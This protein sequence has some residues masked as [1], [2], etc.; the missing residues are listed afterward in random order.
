MS[1]VI[2]LM[3]NVKYQQW[4]CVLNCWGNQSCDSCIEIFDSIHVVF[5][6]FSLFII[7][8]EKN[9]IYYRKETP[10]HCMTRNFQK[11]RSIKVFV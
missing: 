4:Q 11:F 7:H 10:L 1:S 3:K 6:Y 8:V 5:Y 9:Q 2:S